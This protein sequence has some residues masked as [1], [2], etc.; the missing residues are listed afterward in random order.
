[1]SEAYI[2]LLVSTA[3]RPIQTVKGGTAS[4]H[5]DSGSNMASVTLQMVRPTTFWTVNVEE[6]GSQ[7][8]SLSG[9]NSEKKQD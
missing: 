7:P 1:M 8:E 6:D 2:S 4:L 9:D 3:D 5:C